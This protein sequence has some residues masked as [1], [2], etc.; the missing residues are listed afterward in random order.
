MQ[1][2]VENPAQSRRNFGLGRIGLMTPRQLSYL[3]TRWKQGI[4][5]CVLRGFSAGTW[6]S[7]KNDRCL[8]VDNIEAQF[9]EAGTLVV[10]NEGHESPPSSRSIVATVLG[11]TDGGERAA[12]SADQAC[13]VVFCR[14]STVPMA[15]RAA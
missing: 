14:Q 7:R 11:R 10:V 4:A 2:N 5:S 8:V 12:T 1:V 9:V 13:P 3:P 15:E 6:R